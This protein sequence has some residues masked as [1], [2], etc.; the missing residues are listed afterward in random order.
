MYGNGEDTKSVMRSRQWETDKQ[1][2]DQKIEKKTKWPTMVDKTLY[3][4][5]NIEQ[6]KTY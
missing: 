5:Q 3:R 1:Y 6:H 2:N 4:K